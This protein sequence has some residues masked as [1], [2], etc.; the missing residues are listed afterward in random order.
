MKQIKTLNKVYHQKLSVEEAYQLLFNV[1]VKLKQTHFIKV[2]FH[3]KEHPIFTGI[4]SLFTILP[5]P[6]GLIKF[7]IKRKSLDN[8]FITNKDLI[9]LITSKHVYIEV[10]SEDAY[11]KIK[12]L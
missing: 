10:D 4:C 2:K 11:I 6:T 12:T 7:F 9:Q 3:F 5:I 8:D 1:K